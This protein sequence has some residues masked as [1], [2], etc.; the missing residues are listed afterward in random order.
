LIRPVQ[1][2]LCISSLNWEVEHFRFALFSEE[3]KEHK[4][5][6]NLYEGKPPPQTNKQKKEKK[7]KEKKE[8]SHA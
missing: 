5:L 1:F 3:G 7:A 8:R 6:E 2:G 4:N